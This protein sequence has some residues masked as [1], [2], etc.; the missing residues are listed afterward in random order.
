MNKSILK[1]KTFWFGIITA[2]VPLYTPVADWV[3][4]NL[5]MMT[6]IWGGLAVALRLITKDKIVLVD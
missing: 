3:A 5:V 1:S 2:I 6:S 4:G